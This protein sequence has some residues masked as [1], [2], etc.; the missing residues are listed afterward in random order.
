M[1]HQYHFKAKRNYFDQTMAF[2]LDQ[3]IWWWTTFKY[4]IGYLKKEFSYGGCYAKMQ[5]LVSTVV[6]L[7]H[8]LQYGWAQQ[9]PVNKI[10]RIR[11]K[12][13]SWLLKL[14]CYVT[15]LLTYEQWHFFSGAQSFI[16]NFDPHR[17]KYK[18]SL[19]RAR[20]CEALHKP[21]E[22]P[23][24][25]TATLAGQHARCHN[26]VKSV[27]WYQYLHLSHALQTN[28]HTSLSHVTHSHAHTQHHQSYK[29][30]WG[31]KI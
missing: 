17:R 13:V 23:C 8:P 14:M 7:S 2:R 9:R 28:P 21:R 1:L 11:T 12:C 18:H 24:V 3:C 29:D 22:K 26:T 16:W 6:V 25:G 5:L 31:W 4:C 30:C 27:I 10:L 15:A 20:G 19:S